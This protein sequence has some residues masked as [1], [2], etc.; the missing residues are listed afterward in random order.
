MILILDTRR[1]IVRFGLISSKGEQRYRS[2]AVTRPEAVLRAMERFL[3]S[4]RV[5]LRRIRQVT[6]VL[7]PGKFSYVRAGVVIANALALANR[8][9]IRGVRARSEDELISPSVMA[10]RS[11]ARQ[12]LE[13]WY[14]KGP[15]IT[16]AGRKG[17]RG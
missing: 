12:R 6:V 2:F 9:A 16:I 10:K 8:L 4:E 15:S 14:G 13:P 5:T 1:A 17:S 7:G 11:A 3:K